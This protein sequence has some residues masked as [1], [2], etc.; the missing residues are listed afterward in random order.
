MAKYMLSYESY[1]KMVV[2]SSIWS[3]NAVRTEWEILTSLIILKIFL[4]HWRIA[5]L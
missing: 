5:T 1:L 2:L 3:S 4:L